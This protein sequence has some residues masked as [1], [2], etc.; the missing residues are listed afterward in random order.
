M[1]A[2]IAPASADATAMP[3]AQATDRI[4][5]R[6]PTPATAANDAATVPTQ[7]STARH[8]FA[9]S[10]CASDAYIVASSTSLASFS[11]A[12]RRGS[13]II[14]ALVACTEDNNGICPLTWLQLAEFDLRYLD[15]GPSRLS[16]ER[17]ILTP[18]RCGPILVRNVN[19]LLPLRLDHEVHTVAVNG[20]EVR[21]V[22]PEIR[23]AVRVFNRE[24]KSARQLGEGDNIRYILKELSKLSLKVV[25][26]CDQIEDGLAS[27]KRWPGERE[28]L[29]F[30]E[31]PTP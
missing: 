5:D 29:G 27:L 19:V 2:E 24:A 6:P 10:N 8:R 26:G 20:H 30:P 21:F 9:N 23:R 28:R 13:S 22:V 16:E 17:R 11:M 25:V 3:P 12:A 7:R 4:L 1:V 14:L 31:R 18:D 15:I